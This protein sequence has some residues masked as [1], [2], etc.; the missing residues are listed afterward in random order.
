[1]ITAI[2]PAL[3]NRLVECFELEV[4]SAKYLAHKLPGVPVGYFTGKSFLAGG[5]GSRHAGF[6]PSAHPP[7][8]T[9]RFN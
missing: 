8:V 7:P 2:E 6:I 5:L 3:Y 4:R 9:Q 1:L